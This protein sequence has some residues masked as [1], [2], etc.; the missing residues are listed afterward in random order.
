MKHFT[1]QA[2]KGYRYVWFGEVK[3]SF[4]VRQLITWSEGVL[5]LPEKDLS[6][7]HHPVVSQ[8]TA[9]AKILWINC[10]ATWIQFSASGASWSKITMKAYYV[11][12]HENWE[13]V[14]MVCTHQHNSGFCLEESAANSARSA[15]PYSKFPG[16]HPPVYFS[17]CTPRKCNLARGEINFCAARRHSLTSKLIKTFFFHSRHNLII[18]RYIRQRHL[19]QCI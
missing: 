8:Y 11:A 18:E 5:S 1:D 15:W 10:P 3:I 17:E 4:P 19:R 14:E 2:A 7:I 6:P 16:H 9:R 13:S 12:Y